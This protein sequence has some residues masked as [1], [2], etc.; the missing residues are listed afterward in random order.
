[1][2]ALHSQRCCWLAQTC[3][4]R[5]TRNVPV[6]YCGQARLVITDT[7]INRFD[8]FQLARQQQVETLQVIKLGFIVGKKVVVN[9]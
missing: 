8:H 3:L 5:I 7:W 6:P 1:M 4:L 2:H 9:T